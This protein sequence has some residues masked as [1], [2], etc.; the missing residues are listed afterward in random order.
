MKSG[1]IDL[2]QYATRVSPAELTQAVGQ[3]FRRDFSISV[4]ELL[5]HPAVAMDFCNVVRERHDIPNVPDD[6]IL[7]LLLKSQSSE[8]GSADEK[9]INTFP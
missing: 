5:V 1:S 7:R 9:V 3:Q 2:G 4:Q 8:A 6:V